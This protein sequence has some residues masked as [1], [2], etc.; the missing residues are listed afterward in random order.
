M[1]TLFLF[2]SIF[3]FTSYFNGC[4]SKDEMSMKQLLRD[5]PQGVTTSPN[6]FSLSGLNEIRYFIVNPKDKKK[7]ALIE[8]K[9]IQYSLKREIP[10]FRVDSI[11]KANLIIRL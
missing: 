5:S 11:K 1:K 10:V 8:E 9:A 3:L 7:V 2:F 4:E 6:L